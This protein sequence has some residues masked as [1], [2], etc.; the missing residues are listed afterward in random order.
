MPG[1]H[2]QNPG[3]SIQLQEE[4]TERGVQKCQLWKKKQSPRH[5]GEMLW[6]KNRVPIFP[7][8]KKSNLVLT[9]FLPPGWVLTTFLPPWL[10]VKGWPPLPPGWRSCGGW[11]TPWTWSCRGRGGRI[12]RWGTGGADG[13]RYSYLTD[14]LLMPYTHLTDTLPIS[15]R[16]LPTTLL[17]RGPYSYWSAVHV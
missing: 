10:G 12:T 2:I 17:P 5:G 16:Y 13:W 3:S 11:T 15:Y 7:A 1:S 9:T 14:N 4:V 6:N 8:L